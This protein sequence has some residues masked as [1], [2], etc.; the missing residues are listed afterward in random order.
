MVRSSSVRLLKGAMW[1]ASLARGVST[2]RVYGRRATLAGSALIA[3]SLGGDA[4]RAAPSGYTEELLSVGGEQ[5]AVR[6]L[7]EAD[8]GLTF[9]KVPLDDKI[10]TQPWPEEWPFPDSAFSR[11]DETDD[12]DFCTS[13]RL[14]CHGC[15][16]QL[17]PFCAAA[18]QTQRLASCTTLTRAP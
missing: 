16:W 17:S 12:G 1:M 18:S 8:T 6:R 9:Q 14:D 7:V 2:S 5:M 10:F 11:A 15:P 4:A 13:T 3:A